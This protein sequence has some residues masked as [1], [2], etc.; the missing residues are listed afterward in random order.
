MAILGLTIKLL[1]KLDCYYRYK[2]NERTNAM[3]ETQE[4][5]FKLFLDAFNPEDLVKEG[6]KFFEKSRNEDEKRIKLAISLTL[7]SLIHEFNDDVFIKRLSEF[8][9]KHKIEAKQFNQWYEKQ[10]VKELF[11][12]PKSG[13]LYEAI[14]N[15][16]DNKKFHFWFNSGTLKFSTIHSFKGWET[17]TLFLI[18]EPRYADGE[19]DLSFDEL[20]YT[21]LTRSKQNLIILNYGNNEYH[22]QLEELCIGEVK[23]VITSN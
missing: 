8:F 7:K 4:L 15:V 12:N 19:F 3:F 9:V 23:Q 13:R 14:K 20:I 16:R 6:L 10:S 17:N 22:K 1:R 21:G 2:T 18:L 11:G 5:W